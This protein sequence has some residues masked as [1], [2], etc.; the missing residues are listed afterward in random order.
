V[1]LAGGAVEIPIDLLTITLLAAIEQRL[2]DR[3]Y[4]V[5]GI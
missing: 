5:A 4:R 2:P 1:R 3:P